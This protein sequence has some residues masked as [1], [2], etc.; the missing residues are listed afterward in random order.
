[1]IKIIN[2][3]YLNRTPGQYEWLYQIDVKKHTLY[4]SDQVMPEVLK[5]LDDY[6]ALYY[7]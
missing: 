7:T 2:I 5:L 4:A 6:T 3:D 1:M